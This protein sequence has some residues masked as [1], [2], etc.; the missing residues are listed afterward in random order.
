MTKLLTFPEITDRAE[1]Q[2]VKDHPNNPSERSSDTLDLLVPWDIP[3]ECQLSEPVKKQIGEGLRSLLKILNTPNLSQSHHQITHLLT[4]FPKPKTQPAQVKST[5]TALS[6]A[7]VEDFDTYF[8]TN[9]IQTK[10]DDDTALT[11][12]YGLITNCHKFITLCHHTPQ[13][14]PQHV[15]QQKQGFISYSL[16][17][18]RVFNINNLEQ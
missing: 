10:T 14:S 1:E 9:H 13:L 18:T 7:A 16:L 2:S 3:L 11:L 12:T 8:K 17:L 15:T 4:T 5:K 6:P